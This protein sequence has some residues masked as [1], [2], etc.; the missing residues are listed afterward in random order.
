[1]YSEVLLNR[2]DHLWTNAPL[3]QRQRLF[4]LL[5]PEGL[6]YHRE[7]GFRTPVTLS[8]FRTF[9]ETREEGKEWCARRDSNP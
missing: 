2:A 4:G 7:D 5:F 8:L 1:R 9:V 6:E 3:E